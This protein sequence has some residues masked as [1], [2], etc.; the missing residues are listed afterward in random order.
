MTTTP[1]ATNAV[2]GLKVASTNEDMFDAA[3]HIKSSHTSELVIALCGP[4]GSPLHDVAD[5]FKGILAEK[6]GYQCVSLRL[7]ALIEQHAGKAPPSP[8]FDR[9]KLL[10]EKGDL[11]H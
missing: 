4:I 11:S 9:I 5:A 8:Q 6:F 2:V 1:I 10:I 7:S 3:A